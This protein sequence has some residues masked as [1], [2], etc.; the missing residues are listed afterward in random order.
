[1]AIWEIL[2]DYMDYKSKDLN[3]VFFNDLIKCRSG[4]A[5]LVA[6]VNFLFNKGYFE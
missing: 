5:M 1:M 3:R 6:R 4:S 2:S